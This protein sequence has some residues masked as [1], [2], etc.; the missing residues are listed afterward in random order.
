MSQHLANGS[1]TDVQSNDFPDLDDAGLAARLRQ[2]ISTIRS[3]RS[4][5]PEKL[6]PGVR[7]GRVW[8]Y[9]KKTTE[10]WLAAR[11][12]QFR[13]VISS[14][15]TIAPTR[16]KRKGKPTNAEISAASKAGLTVPAW[17]AQQDSLQRK[18]GNL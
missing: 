14:E 15:Q 3:W 10:A 17:R 12:S 4:R 16:T 8:L 18:E 7:V 11:Q 6:P 9:G 5:N 2:S 13:S 1:G